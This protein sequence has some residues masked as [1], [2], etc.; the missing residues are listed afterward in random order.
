[1]KE[2]FEVVEIKSKTLKLKANR[3]S[4]CHNCSANNGCGTGLLSKHFN[5]YSV[6]SK[7]VQKGLKVGDII[8]LEI[9]SKELFYRAFQLYILPLFALFLGGLLSRMF[10][11]TNELGQ[12]ISA[13]IGF[14]I[15]LLFVK[16]LVK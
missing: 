15:A 9:S 14:F 10:Y 16:Y 12:I 6:F 8:T 11:P 1:M 5:R 7:H 4:P 2:K 13:F 3:T